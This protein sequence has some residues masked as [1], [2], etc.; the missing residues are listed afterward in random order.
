MCETRPLLALSPGDPIIWEPTTLK[1]IAIL[2]GPVWLGV[3]YVF[4]YLSGPHLSGLSG[5][6]TLSAREVSLKPWWGWSR[7][8][9]INAQIRLKK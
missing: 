8:E 9:I 6:S 2:S 1:M 3:V 5:L 4:G 7:G